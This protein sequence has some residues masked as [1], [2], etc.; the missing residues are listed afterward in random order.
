MG[1][2]PFDLFLVNFETVL[3]NFIGYAADPVQDAHRKVPVASY[4]IQ[5]HLQF[6]ITNMRLFQCRNG[7]F[8]IG[9]GKDAQ[10]VDEVG[11]FIDTQDLI[12]ARFIGFVEL[13]QSTAKVKEGFDGFPLFSDDLSA[14]ENILASG[15]VYLFIFLIRQ[16]C[17]Q[18]LPVYAG[19]AIGYF[20]NDA[21]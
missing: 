19:F 1:N 10:Q 11:G 9:I 4:H 15:I 13:H 18:H 12:F 14:I 21:H 3:N 16:F 5:H 20:F 8:V 6:H 2:P 17:E 7:I